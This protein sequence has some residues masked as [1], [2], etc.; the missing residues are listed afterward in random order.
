MRSGRYE[1]S[2]CSLSLLQD[3]VT[4]AL[5][6][7]ASLRK[8]RSLPRKNPALGSWVSGSSLTWNSMCTSSFYQLSMF[9]CI[10]YSSP[11]VLLN[12]M[13]RHKN[14]SAPNRFAIPLDAWD[15]VPNGYTAWFYNITLDLSAIFRA[16]STKDWDFVCVLTKA[17]TFFLTRVFCVIS[18]LSCLQSLCLEL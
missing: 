7:Q 9:S 1:K 10:F 6:F 3:T 14:I 12:L 18:L 4:T 17:D 15:S 16:K 2:L 5:T 11:W 8:L 13:K